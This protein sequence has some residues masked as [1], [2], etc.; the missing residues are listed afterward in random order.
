MTGAI[1]GKKVNI[2][3]DRHAQGDC[4]TSQEH[5]VLAVG[6]KKDV[7]YAGADVLRPLYPVKKMY[8]IQ[9]AKKRYTFVL[10]TSRYWATQVFRQAGPQHQ[11]AAVKQ[12]TGT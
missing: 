1:W 10:T 3:K 12:P 2:M 5:S 4:L 9:G 6:K 8:C 11:Q 7:L